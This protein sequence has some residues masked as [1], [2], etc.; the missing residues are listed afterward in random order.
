VHGPAPTR[1]GLRTEAGC[2]ID[3]G[4]DHH[5]CSGSQPT[6]LPLDVPTPQAHIRNQSL[7]EHPSVV[8]S[9]MK[10]HASQWVSLAILSGLDARHVHGGI[11]P[12]GVGMFG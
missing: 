1:R 2:C 6:G 8:L 7:L 4:G 9:T 3:L 11:Y 5:D 12:G 10:P